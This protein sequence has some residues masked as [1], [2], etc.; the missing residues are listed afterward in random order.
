VLIKSNQAA[1]PH[2]AALRAGALAK[3][4]GADAA[5]RDV[6]AVTKAGFLNF[7]VAVTNSDT[8][9]IDIKMIASAGTVTDAG[10]NVYQTVKIGS[11]TWTV[12]NLR[13]TKYNDGTPIPL[14]VSLSEWAVLS[15]PGYC[16]YGST[17][18]ADSIR[19]FGALYNWYA[20]NTKKLAPA[21]WHVPDTLEWLAMQNYLVANGF[22]WDGTTADNK[23]GKALAAKAD[24]SVSTVD[25][26]IGNDLTKNNRTGFS[27]MPGGSRYYDVDCNYIGQMGI[28]WTATAA[29]D[30]HAYYRML[31]NSLDFLD[32]YQSASTTGF[33]VRLVKD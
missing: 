20:V 23:I 3:Q 29:D 24:W 32:L 27:A 5:M 11:Q 33:S 30:A 22:N 9:G 6:I 14:A 7:R 25:G 19:K 17:T 26:A 13:T 4:A 28:W 12:E 8:S 2:T 15:T 16:Y 1:G 10:G 31:S 18:N 21:G